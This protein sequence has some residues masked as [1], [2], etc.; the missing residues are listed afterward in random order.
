MEEFTVYVVQYWVADGYDYWNDAA[1]PSTGMFV[2]PVSSY[3]TESEG[4]ARLDMLEAKYPTAKYRLIH[5]TTTQV[6]L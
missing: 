6:V 5:R 3:E 4:R 1:E 2:L